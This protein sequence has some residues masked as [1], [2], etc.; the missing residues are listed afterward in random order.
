MAISSPAS[1][2]RTILVLSADVTAETPVSLAT[3][4][5]AI[6]K[7]ERLVGV[8]SAEISTGTLLAA[9]KSNETTPVD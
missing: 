2:V 5:S 1:L 9:S 6:A 4:F 3:L 7:F 8:T